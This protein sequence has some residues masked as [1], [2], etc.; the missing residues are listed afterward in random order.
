MLTGGPGSGK[1]TVGRQ[2]MAHLLDI[3]ETVGVIALEESLARVGWD[4]VGLKAGRLLHRTRLGVDQGD[5]DAAY[6]DTLGTGRLHLYNHQG[7]TGGATLISKIRVMSKVLGC[8]YILLD[9]ITIA[10][11]QVGSQQ[12]DERLLIDSVM[13]QLGVLSGE[14]DIHIAVVCHLK[15]KADGTSFDDGSQVSQS[16]LRGSASL[17]QMSH[18]IIAVERNQQSDDDDEK[19]SLRIRVLKDRWTGTTGIAGWLRFNRETGRLTECAA[20]KKGTNNAAQGFKDESASP[21]DF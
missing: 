18:T 13:T 17:E 15:R 11:T 9:H 19:N 5:L 16:D 4:M 12:S 8:R 6:R 14:L 3:G 7:N 1:S 2:M 10:L 21:S 20:P